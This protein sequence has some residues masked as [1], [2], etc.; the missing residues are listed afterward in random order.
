MSDARKNTENPEKDTNHS[1]AMQKHE[2]DIVTIPKVYEN[3]THFFCKQITY[4]PILT[5]NANHTCLLTK[6]EK[7]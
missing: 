2:I 4:D 3:S 7:S 6:S 5:H 1:V